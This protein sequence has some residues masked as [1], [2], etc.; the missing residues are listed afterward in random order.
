MAAQAVNATNGIVV[1]RG[2]GANVIYRGFTLR[3]TGGAAALV[4]IRVNTATGKILDVI[5]MVA[6]EG[7]ADFYEDGI[8]CDGDLY[9]EIATGAVEGTIRY[10]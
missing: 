3:E 7:V 9:C 8:Y 1:D 4:K 10:S 2:I 5:P 6:G